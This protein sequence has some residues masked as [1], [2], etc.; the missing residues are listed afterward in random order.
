MSR[1]STHGKAN[2]ECYYFFRDRWSRNKEAIGIRVHANWE[3]KNIIGE[4]NNGS[5]TWVDAIWLLKGDGFPLKRPNINGRLVLS[6]LSICQYV[7]STDFLSLFIDFCTR[8]AV[9]R[10][11][12]LC[13]QHSVTIL[14]MVR[15]S[16]GQNHNTVSYLKNGK[17]RIPLHMQQ[18]C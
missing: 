7:Q 17:K 4:D 5:R 1:G 6:N 11:A 10:A 3:Q 12:G 15:R 9:K 16:C 8:N 14:A 13:A 2:D 18:L